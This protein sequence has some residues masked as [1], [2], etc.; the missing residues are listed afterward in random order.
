MK[1]IHG[2]TVL[3]AVALLAGCGGEESKAEEELFVVPPGK[4]DNFYSLSAQEYMV[5]G[6]AYVEL[7]ESY[8][9][10]DDVTRTDRLNHLIHCRQIAVNWFLLTYLM[11]PEDKHDNKFESLTKNGSYEDL[12]ITQ[13][14]E[15]SRRYTFKLRQ[16]V[17]GQLDLLNELPA[18]LGEDGKHH[19]NLPVGKV[20]NAD[21]EKLDLGEE[22]YRKAPWKSFNPATADESILEHI[23]LTIWPE[24]RSSDGWIDYNRLFENGKLTVSIHFG[25]DY[26]KEYHLVH[27]EDVYN[28][29]TGQGFDSPVDSY[30][31]YNRTSG[32]LT[33]TIT[34]NGNDVDVSIWMYWGKAGTDVDPD[35][36]A[37]GKILEDDMIAALGTRDVIMFSGHSG[38]FYG[39][40]LAN[41]R[42]TK[43]GDLDDSEIPG[44]DMP[45]D[46]YQVVLAEG[47]DTYA[48]GQAFRDNPN[49]LG[50]NNLDVLTT[51]NFSN[52]STAGVVRNM[53]ESL[54]DDDYDGNHK[55]WK[56]SELLR[57]LD[58]NSFW[59]HSMYGVHGIDDNPRLHPYARVDNFCKECSSNDDCGSEGNRCVR[60]SEEEKVCS[61]ECLGT[62]ACPD[63]YECRD[64]GEGSYLKYRLCVP[65]GLTCLVEPELPSKQIMIN[66]IL[67][68]PAPDLTGDAN[69]DGER[70]ATE[71]EFIELVSLSAQPVDLTGWFRHPVCVSRRQRDH[72]RPRRGGVRRRRAER[73]SGPAHRGRRSDTHRVGTGAQQRWGYHQPRGAGRY[74]RRFL[75]L[76]AG[77][78]P[79][80][81]GD[82]VG[83][84]RSR[85]GLRTSPRRYPVLPGNQI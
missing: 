3:L 66:E 1:T 15:N 18:T 80:P 65:Q 4:A 50:L 30:A 39:F 13:D 34:A 51:T 26:H 61:A 29:L 71:D 49:K 56:Y 62:D 63:G 60:L 16:E 59:F 12:E 27:S 58:S 53:V 22:W 5:E 70:H 8:D 76:R 21:M 33:K 48:M 67:A 37:G 55:P 7:E 23:E 40:A 42:K 52:A 64:V 83:G 31:D 41:W 46:K 44:I 85:F 81:L 47:C 25:W 45:A 2:L 17:G 57:R 10:A 9:D 14:P 79:G 74:H 84:R 77:S 68:D 24:P 35:T 54:I 38:P 75:L 78:G 82:Q 72:C 20:A 36:D 11:G 43:A 32:P 69:G 19:F 73:D 6:I 28:W